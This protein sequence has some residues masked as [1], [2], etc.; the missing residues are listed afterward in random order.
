M[1]IIHVLLLNFLYFHSF[2]Q[3]HA[4]YAVIGLEH[5]LDHSEIRRGK[6]KLS[7]VIQKSEHNP[8]TL[9]GILENY[10]IHRVGNRLITCSPIYSLQQSTVPVT[11][12]TRLQ[13]TRPWTSNYAQGHVGLYVPYKP[14]NSMYD[15]Y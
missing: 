10:C 7:S 5:S 12:A 9:E 11:S 8:K 15:D 14:V 3:H 13:I 6:T 1:I 2:H 4:I